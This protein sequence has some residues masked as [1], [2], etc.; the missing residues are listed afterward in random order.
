MPSSEQ[1]PP[2]LHRSPDATIRIMTMPKSD[3]S[4]AR[5]EAMYRTAQTLLPGGVSS[6]FRLGGSPVPLFFDRAQGSHLVDVDG[7]DYVDYALGMGPNILG[8]APARVVNAVADSL[9]RGQLFAGQHVGEI[10]LAEKIRQLVPSVELVRFG[11]SGSEM[12]QA[13]LRVTRAITGKRL[14][15]KFEGHYHG[16]FDTILVSVSPP[17]NQ[18]G[19]AE[20]PVPHLPSDGQS[21]AAARDVAVL[22]WNDIKALDSFLVA[23]ADQTAAVIMEPI[24]CNTCVIVPRPGYLEAVR[25]LCSHLGVVLIFDEVIT[26][27]RVG[28]GGAQTLL[29]V[30]PDLTVFAKALGAGFPIAALGGRRDLMAAF[31]SGKVLHGG[32]FNSNLVSV[33]AALSALN[34]LA[35]DDGAVYQS[36]DEKGR[37]LMRELGA[38]ARRKGIN[39]L[40]Q[41]LGSV[42]NTAFTPRE[43]IVDYRSYQESDLTVQRRFLKALQDVGVRVTSRGTWF[44]SAAHTDADIDFTLTATAGVL[45]SL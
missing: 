33:S 21:A 30:Q 37:R 39:L 13:A 1:A 32:T 25:K 34:I 15:V 29:G 27:F 31:G 24:L 28:L 19:P 44:L 8:H 26:G 20:A 45:D 43:A 6:N 17:L 7:N 38:L 41:G 18:A 11:L 42:F 14:V 9:H 36:M 3:R 12:V 10:E 4:Y 2:L 16:W 40:V 22:P 23:H 5:S 35:A